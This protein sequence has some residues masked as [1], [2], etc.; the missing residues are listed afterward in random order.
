MDGRG[1]ACIGIESTRCRKC[2][3][4]AR[5]VT[6][7]PPPRRFEVSRDD[8]A[9]LVEARPLGEIGVLFGVSDTAVAKRCRV[10]G[11]QLHGRGY[12]AKLRAGVAGNTLGVGPKDAGFETSARNPGISVEIRVPELD[13]GSSSWQDAAL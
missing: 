7:P 6:L 5:A 1:L 13:P 8:L 9:A 12:W 3:A 2:A 10:L 4:R 11:I